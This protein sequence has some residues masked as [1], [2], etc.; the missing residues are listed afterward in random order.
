MGAFSL[1]IFLFYFG[2]RERESRHSVCLRLDLLLESNCSSNVKG[3]HKW[4][5]LC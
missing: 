3:A 1:D 5:D 2:E 4:H